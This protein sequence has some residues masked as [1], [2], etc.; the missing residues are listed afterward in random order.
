MFL[1]AL[2]WEVSHWRLAGGGRNALSHLQRKTIKAFGLAPVLHRGSQMTSFSRSLASSVA[3]AWLVV[4]AGTDRVEAA[5]EQATWILATVGDP[6]TKP[7]PIGQAPAGG[8]SR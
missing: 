2:V 4:A 8:T 3:A 1:A 6:K 5:G 7:P